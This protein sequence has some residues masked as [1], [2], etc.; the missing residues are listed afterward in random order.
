M[1][2]K[3][4]GYPTLFRRCVLTLARVGIDISPLA[5]RFRNA[6]LRPHRVEVAGLFAQITVKFDQISMRLDQINMKFDQVQAELRSA[7]VERDELHQ[8]SFLL[9]QLLSGT[10]AARPPGAERA[11]AQMPRP[12]VAVILPTYNRATF[13]GEAISSVQAQSFQDWELVVVDDG[14]T[15]DTADVVASFSTDQRIRYVRQ[16]RA[17]SAAARNRGIAETSAPLISYIDSD[18]L[19]YPD[20][21][22]RSVDCLSTEQEVDLIYGALVSE[23]HGLDRRCILWKPFDRNTLTQGNFIDTNVIVHRRHLVTRLGG[24][25]ESLGR[26]QDWDLVLRYT[27]DKPAMPLNVLAAYTRKCDNKRITDIVDDEPFMAAIQRKLLVQHD[28]Q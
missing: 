15:D 12:T 2:F 8:R 20:F 6:I 1:E 5:Q 18:N 26:F 24:W 28:L 4:Q 27:V 16:G 25:D 22:K 19:W 21:L 7:S 23:V 3:V 11:V 14:S 13:I 9:E 10:T 17:N